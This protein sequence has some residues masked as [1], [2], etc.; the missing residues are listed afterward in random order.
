MEFG[1]A[2]KNYPSRSI[3][4]TFCRAGQ[5]TG[6]RGTGAGRAGQGGQNR[7]NGAGRGGVG[8]WAGVLRGAEGSLLLLSYGLIQV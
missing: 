4:I 5:G 8:R 3:A 7:T 6:H 1:A 2:E